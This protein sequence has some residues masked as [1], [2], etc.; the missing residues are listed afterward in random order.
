MR[1]V[2]ASGELGFVWA[3]M[4]STLLQEVSI[5]VFSALPGNVLGIT[6]HLALEAPKTCSCEMLSVS[7]SRLGEKCKFLSCSMSRACFTGDGDGRSR[8]YTPWGG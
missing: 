1:R 8:K 6:A 3:A 7:C 5:G 2:C 4:G